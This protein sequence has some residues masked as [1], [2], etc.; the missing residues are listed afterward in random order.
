MM[1]IL[2]ISGSR[3]PDGQ[4]A[5]ALK[6]VRTG[7]LRAGAETETVFLPTLA[8]ERCRQCDDMRF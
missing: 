1:N 6:A 3:N 4:T 7:L 8:V 2:L 5:Q